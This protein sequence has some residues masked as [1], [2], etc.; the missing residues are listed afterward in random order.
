[1]TPTASSRRAGSPPLRK[2]SRRTRWSAAVWSDHSCIRPRSSPVR[3]T[4]TSWR[5]PR[6][7]AASVL[8]GNLGFRRE[9]FD[10]LGGF[11][12]QLPRGEDLDFGWRAIDAGFE[13]RTVP[14]AVVHYRAQWRP[15]AVLGR[16]F[17]DGQ[18]GPALYV[19][20]RAAGLRPSSPTELRRRYADLARGL[21][22]DAWSPSRR[23]NWLYDVGFCL[24]RVAGSFRNGVR[25]L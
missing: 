23:P 5:S 22:H 13:P 18:A 8:A 17:T 3:S 21:L 19:R 2:R 10:L 20:H 15:L 12:E 24:G 16:G 9:V 25:Y 6:G 4:R 7:I 14:D 1:M 11:D